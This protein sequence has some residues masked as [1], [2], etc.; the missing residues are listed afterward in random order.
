MFSRD[1][2]IVSEDLIDAFHYA[3][4]YSCI[5]IAIIIRAAVDFPIFLTVAI[6]LMILALCILAAY[7]KKLKIIKTEFQKANDEL[8]H[9]I[10]DSIEGVKV[11]RTADGTVWAIDLLNEAFRNARIAIV[12]SENCNIW[13]MRRLDPISVGLAISTLIMCTQLDT[14][15]FPLLNDSILKLGIQQSLG[16]LVF[17][18]WSLKC[19]GTAIYT[20]GSVERIHKCVNTH[21]LASKPTSCFVSLAP[22][23]GTSKTSPASL[24]TATTSNLSGL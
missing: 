19:M 16:Y 20:M 22:K 13:L 5:F 18:A 1:L 24:S 12:A 21:P 8:F 9:A 23:T 2:N 3:V 17:V 7:Q 6:P 10:C 14:K 11:L 4:L 15:E